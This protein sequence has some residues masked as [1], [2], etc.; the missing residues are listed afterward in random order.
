MKQIRSYIQLT[1]FLLL[2]SCALTSH[3]SDEEVLLSSTEKLPQNKIEEDWLNKVN[4]QIEKDEYNAS[5]QQQDSEGV[6]FRE[7]K[8][9]FVNRK[10]DFRSYF[11]KNSWELRQREISKGNWKWKYNFEQLIRDNETAFNPINI[12]QDAK[13]KIKIDYSDPKSSISISQWFH[14]TE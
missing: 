6:K 10:Q 11:D 7:E 14:N 12:S 13:D 3:I 9:H 5:L 1:F 2:S 4:K 8:W